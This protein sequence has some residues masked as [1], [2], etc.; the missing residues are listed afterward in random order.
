[1]HSRR[2]GA[3]MMAVAAVVALGTMAIGA[4]APK[5]GQ[6]WVATWGTAQQAFRGPSAPAAASPPA[7]AATSAGTSSQAA[8]AIPPAAAGRAVPQRRFGIPAA[9]PGLHD[10]TLRLIVRTSIGGQTV[11]VRLSQAFGAAAVTVGAAHVAIRAAGA[12]IVPES[13]RVLTFS[14][15][16]STMI[17]AGQVAVSDPVKLDVKPSSDLA[18]GLYFPGETGPPTGHTFG[19][20]PTYVSTQGDATASVT[21]ADRVHH[22]R[23]LLLAH[24]RGRPGPGIG[25]LRW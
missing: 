1:M 18:I 22:G 14:G 10:Q 20:R 12:A 7:S 3:G 23:V 4:A 9:V 2:T 17:Y 19:L 21:I 11:R 24:R 25:R 15:K 13:D 8:A 16:P 6:R 5:S